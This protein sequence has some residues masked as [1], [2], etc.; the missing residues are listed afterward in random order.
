MAKSKA[1]GYQDPDKL[2][3]YNPELVGPNVDVTLVW[4]GDR[5]AP[6][7][8]WSQVKNAMARL[9]NWKGLVFYW[10]VLEYQPGD[11]NAAWEETTQ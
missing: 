6:K 10:E 3:M 1:A 11:V 5:S 9:R 4:L 8:V 7:A 2:C